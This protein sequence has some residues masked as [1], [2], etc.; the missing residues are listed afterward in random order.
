MVPEAWIFFWIAV[1]FPDAAAVNPNGIKTILAS[2]VSTCYII[3]NAVV[4]D[5][6]RGLPRIIPDCTILDV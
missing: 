4:S 1:S 2:D 6:P 3:C 5:G